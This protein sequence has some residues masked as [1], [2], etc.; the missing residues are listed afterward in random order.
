MERPRARFVDG[1]QRA[2]SGELGAATAYRWHATSLASRV[3]QA[4]V[5]RIGT[6]EVDHRERLGRMLALVGAGPR[7]E[8]EWRNRLLGTGIGLF[9]QVG[10]WFMP[11]YGAGWLERRNIVEYEL[12]AR[13]ALQCGRSS[14]AADLLAMAEVEWEHE[15][16]FRSK[17]G[18]HLFSRVFRT[19]SPP[20]PKA[21]I[22]QGFDD[23]ARQVDDLASPPASSRGS[24]SCAVL[25]KL[26]ARSARAGIAAGPTG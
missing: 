21:S 2:Y 26:Q 6:E 3:E 25:Q 19:W 1:L 5:T 24:R 12:L 14:F 10:G 13:E 16:Y 7:A 15:L 20:P 8:L 22:R 17:A 9:C 4:E 11:M 18:S 23:F